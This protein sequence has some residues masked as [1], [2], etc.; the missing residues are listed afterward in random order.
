MLR[1]LVDPS[2]LE[3]ATLT[4]RGQEFHYAARVRRARSGETV[5][6]FDGAGRSATATVTEIRT[7]ELD[8]NLAAPQDVPTPLPE[9]WVGAALIKGERMDWMVSKLVELGAARIL[10]FIGERTV[11]RVPPDRARA[12]QQRFERLAQAAS[13]QCRRAHLPHIAPIQSFDEVLRESADVGLKLIP[14]VADRLPPLVSAMP[15]MRPRSLVVLVGPEG[16]FAPEETAAA[17]AAGFVSVSLGPRVL[18]AE[19]AALAAAA[20][21]DLHFQQLP[22]KIDPATP[23]AV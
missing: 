15:P 9:V 4:L 13:R 18:R 21:I 10:P 1:I 14:R 5:E 2:E 19:T 6:V 7:D 8:L 22:R 20:L 11:V 23:S 16:G 17:S 12:R 3:R